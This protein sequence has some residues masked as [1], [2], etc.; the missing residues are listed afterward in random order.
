MRAS[1]GS[2]KRNS[3]S[4]RKNSHRTKTSATIA[5]IRRKNL[6]RK[7]FSAFWT[8]WCTPTHLIR[9]YT[10]RAHSQWPFR[11]KFGVSQQKLWHYRCVPFRLHCSTSEEFRIH[12]SH[13][14]YRVHWCTHRR[15]VKNLKR[16]IFFSRLFLAYTA[17]HSLSNSHVLSSAWL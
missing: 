9:C 10:F 13:T 14:S 8:I 6:P 3:T 5:W 1:T 7:L 15:K 16:I 17:L 11:W 12:I 4:C 2:F